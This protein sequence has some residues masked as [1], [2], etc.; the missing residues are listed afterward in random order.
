M[1]NVEH[2]IFSGTEI[3][4]LFSLG[5][6]VFVDT[7]TAVPRDQPLK[8]SS[9]RTDAGLGIRVAI[10]RAAT[11]P[12][13]R[14]DCAYAFEFRPA[15]PARLARLLLERAGVL[16]RRAQYQRPAVPI[17][18]ARLGREGSRQPGEGSREDAGRAWDIVLR[19]ELHEQESRRGRRR[20]RWETRRRAGEAAPRRI[21]AGRRAPS[22]PGSAMPRARPRPMPASAPRLPIRKAKGRA[23]SAMSGTGAS[24]SRAVRRASSR[25]IRSGSRTATGAGRSA[26]ARGS[27][28][29]PAAGSRRG[30]P[31]ERL[32][33]RSFRRRS[34]RTISCAPS[35]ARVHPSRNVQA[36]PSQSARRAAVRRRSRKSA[37]N[38][39]TEGERRSVGLPGG[40]SS[41]CQ[42]RPAES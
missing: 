33:T 20:R 16:A 3:L 22:E 40:P 32:P 14:L 12:I 10:S 25:G 7:G 24:A 13:L 15:R 29:A 2:R 38:S 35:K 1:L 5:A 18:P 30:R 11:N 19:P 8:F 36:R 17:L 21:P 31:P 27:A 9:L 28:S 41:R 23:R 6:V 42:M 34:R 37:E 39:K 4:Q 26:G